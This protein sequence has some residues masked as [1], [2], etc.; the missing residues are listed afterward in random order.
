MFG[1]LAGICTNMVT[2]AKAIE[3]HV[4]DWHANK[5]PEDVAYFGARDPRDVRLGLIP[6]HEACISLH[7]SLLTSRLNKLLPNTIPGYEACRAAR[8][9]SARGWKTTHV[10][11]TKSQTQR[12]SS[13]QGVRKLKDR[14]LHAKEELTGQGEP[15]YVPVHQGQT[16]EYSYGV[17]S[18][19][20]LASSSLAYGTFKLEQN[21]YVLKIHLK[22]DILLKIV[23]F[24]LLLHLIPQYKLVTQVQW[25]TKYLLTQGLSFSANRRQKLNYQYEYSQKSYTDRKTNHYVQTFYVTTVKSA[26][27]KTIKA[28]LIF[29]QYWDDGTRSSKDNHVEVMR[30]NLQLQTPEF[31]E[32]YEKTKHMAPC[33]PCHLRSYYTT[34]RPTATQKRHEYLQTE[35]V[36]KTSYINCTQKECAISYFQQTTDEMGTRR[37]KHKSANTEDLYGTVKRRQRIESGP[38]TS[39]AMTMGGETSWKHNLLRQ[40]QIIMR[41]E[42]TPRQ[43]TSNNSESERKEPGSSGTKWTCTSYNGESKRTKLAGNFHERRKHQERTRDSIQTVHEEQ[44][45]KVNIQSKEAKYKST[46]EVN[47]YEKPRGGNRSGLGQSTRSNVEEETL[48]LHQVTERGVCWRTRGKRGC[49]EESLPLNPADERLLTKHPHST[50]Y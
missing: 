42:R 4:T 27:W 34:I 16:Y 41:A 7:P 39:N 20:S 48:E 18:G 13:N 10:T 49:S 15:L 32:Q 44:Q 37:T 5:F 40:K 36:K 26:C 21:S 45:G 2:K 3:S 24:T 29:K 6:M 17:D 35:Q 28:N 22:H 9:R 43:T 50:E 31:L 8:K 1:D 19:K 25:I 46:K 30:P 12:S 47:H 23:H 33:R 38:Y 14:L 11:D